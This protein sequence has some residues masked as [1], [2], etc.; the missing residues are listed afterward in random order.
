MITIFTDGAC[1]GNPGPGGWAA[2]TAL[3]D[4]TVRELGGAQSR[5]TNNRMEMTAAI[6]ALRAISGI[7]GPVRLLTDS[8]YLLQGVR[9]WLDGWKRKDWRRIDGGEVLNRDLWEAL[10]VLRLSRPI[11]WLHVRGHAGHPG[12]ERCDVLAVAFSHGE[13][14]P[15]FN[16]SAHS[17]P[18]DLSAPLPSESR[19]A[20]R[21][22]PRSW[23]ADG[24][25]SF[26]PRSQGP[27]AYLSLLDG[28]LERHATWPECQARVHGKNAK[29]KKV[30]SP[31]EEDETLRE[32]GL[33]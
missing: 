13:H 29:F 22:Q 7:A 33:R 4:G 15:L 6:E 26:K 18:V 25:R 1:S 5:T 10:D 31:Q 17:Y 2:V 30:R 3:P 12:N 11:E 23:S 8:S 28:K 21:T 27:A 20:A 9:S 32:W 16:G 19:P 14:P 24:K